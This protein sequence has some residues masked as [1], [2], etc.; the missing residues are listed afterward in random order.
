MDEPLTALDAKLKEYLRIEL[1]Q[2]LRKLGITA[3]YVT[4][5]QLEAMSIADRI[6]VMNLG[7]IEQVDT[8]ERIYSSPRLIL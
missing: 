4:H 5:D 3:I 7:V 6:A 8:P 1:G 2:M